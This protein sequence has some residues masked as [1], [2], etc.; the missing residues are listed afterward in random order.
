M[1]IV[2]LP[3]DILLII[4]S[5][6]HNKK[7]FI[8]FK[9]TCREF[10][11]IAFSL[12]IILRPF[13]TNDQIS[14]NNF[15]VTTYHKYFLNSITLRDKDEIPLFI[16]DCRRYTLDSIFILE[17]SQ[18]FK[19]CLK[20]A[21]FLPNLQILTVICKNLNFS[22]NLPQIKTLDVYCND[23]RLNFENLEKN[24]ISEF[25][26]QSKQLREINGLEKL[27]K[28]TTLTIKKSQLIYI[29]KCICKMVQLV[30]L[31]LSYNR[32][33]KLL[34]SEISN[35]INIES[36]KINST[37][38]SKLP[39]ELFKLKKL[40]CLNLSDTLIS[41]LNPDIINLQNLKHLT[42]NDTDIICENFLLQI[43]NLI[44]L[45]V[46]VYQT[47]ILSYPEIENGEWIFNFRNGM[48]VLDK[49]NYTIKF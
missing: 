31:D 23:E 13:S 28:I 36:L 45:V 37:G 30:K 18:Q 35:L 21:K 2:E 5:N 49:K 33:L 20:R 46:P 25:L 12:S 34:P 6:L 41:Q 4:V 27:K 17:I 44:C 48:I 39:A 40:K 32:S 22:I 38:I 16:N 19:R 43:T 8:R 11:F 14:Y 7:D 29:P 47:F 10:R 24:N 3:D 15:K 26:I 42:F 9:N 1:N